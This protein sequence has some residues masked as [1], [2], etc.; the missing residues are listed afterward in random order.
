[1]LYLVSNPWPLVLTESRSNLFIYFIYLF[2]YLLMRQAKPYL[3][4]KFI[5]LILPLILPCITHIYN[6]IH[7]NQETTILDDQ[8]LETTNLDER[9]NPI[10]CYPFWPP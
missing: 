4:I 2:I 1:M 8:I 9:P 5:K 6:T 3:F 10:I 7:T